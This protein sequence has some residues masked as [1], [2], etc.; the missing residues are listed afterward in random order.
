MSEKRPAESKGRHLVS[1]TPQ[2]LDVL[3]LCKKEVEEDLG[4]NLS[5][6]Q[7]IMYLVKQWKDKK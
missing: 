3:D 1:V 4:V 2:T 7:I 6:N 5:Y